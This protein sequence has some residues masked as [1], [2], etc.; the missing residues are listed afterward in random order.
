MENVYELKNG[1]KVSPVDYRTNKNRL[2][3][4]RELELGSDLFKAIKSVTIGPLCQA[5]PAVL[6]K[7][8][9]CKC[10]NRFCGFDKI[11]KPILTYV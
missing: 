3:P 4:Y 1:V 6:A 7:F 8:L 11:Y 5:S 9:V 10:D 2:I